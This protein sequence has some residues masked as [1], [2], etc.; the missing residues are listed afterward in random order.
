MSSADR[1]LPPDP[2]VE[3]PYRYTSQMALRVAILGVVALGLFAVLFLRLWA[4]QV[5]SG[6]QYANAATRNT[7]RTEPVEA[8][9]GAILDRNG[10]TL[11][12]NVPA[13]AVRV[14]PAEL[15]E[16]AGRDT[17]LRRLA[18]VLDLRFKDLV[19]TIREHRD[20]P[21]TPIKIKVAVHREQV[22]YLKEYSNEFPGVAVKTTFL[23]RYLAESL[24]A[25]VLGYTGQVSAEELKRRRADDV[26]GGDTVGLTGVEAAYDNELRGVSGKD[27]YLVNARGKRT[28][29]AHT[30]YDE[31]AKGGRSVRLTIDI[32]LQRAAERALRYGIEL[33][34]NDE[35][36][37]ANGGAIVA[38]DPANGEVLA[39]A[40]N[41]TYKPGIWVG[42]LD[43]KE[44]APLL[45]Q[46]VAKERNY[47]GLNRAIAGLYP[48]GSTWKPVTALASLMTPNIVEPYQTLQCTPDYTV[49]GQVFKNWNPDVDEPMDMPTAIAASCD[50][51]FYQ[52][53]YR[54]FGLKESAGHPLQDW[55]HRFGFGARTGIDVGPE[56]GGL[57]P[58]P[59]W[60]EKT[61]TKK[62]DPCCWQIDSLWKPGDSIQLSIGQ[63]DLLVTPLQMAAFY[64]M[65]ANGGQRVTPHV[66]L[67]TEDPGRNNE[68]AQVA[69]TGPW[70]TQPTGVDPG[71][72]DAV[73]KGLYQATHESFGTATGVFGS[74][75]IAIAGK[76]GTAE[77]AVH[78]P[79]FDGYMDQSWFCG[80]GPV[81]SSGG[82]S[83]PLGGKSLVVCALI[84]N[85]GHGGTAAAPA[86][87][88]V[89]EQ[90]FGVKG[91]GVE[92]VYSD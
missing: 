30:I 9:R 63:K 92:D 51:Y 70:P 48:A 77:K 7:L 75:P 58:T 49:K 91:G 71:A 88:K 44:L 42:K 86:V 69:P 72:L 10:R 61:Y 67:D 41:P 15:P 20:D 37:A 78:L 46:K 16:G 66:V 39:L 54:I 43:P 50:T 21:Y 68:G 74:F 34:R 53:G 83:V 23:R 26:R 8:E 14:T 35:H 89:F 33:A 25:H 13:N 11:V 5:L 4:L 27:G 24:G 3:E 18:A 64:A 45:D 31:P 57:L 87:R 82:L 52:L 60:R 17:E 80:Y 6:T 29:L 59:A 12:T 79:G 2:R 62:T 56:E 1:F 47:P 55:A 76:T 32:S 85:G 22:L 65:V 38:I 81:N 84:E 40:S 19:A 36:W 90:Y 73:R 28:E